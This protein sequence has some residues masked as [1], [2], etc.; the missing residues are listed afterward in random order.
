MMESRDLQ[1]EDEVSSEQATLSA[2]PGLE[3]G[4]VLQSVSGDA[5]RVSDGF[6]R[7]ENALQ[8]SG[9]RLEAG[10]GFPERMAAPEAKEDP[11]ITEG[12]E[13]YERFSEAVKLI[14]QSSDKPI[15]SLQE[16]EQIRA[17]SFSQNPVD[18][19]GVSLL[20]I[21]ANMSERL[22]SGFKV[23]NSEA[24]GMLYAALSQAEVFFRDLRR[25]NGQKFIEIA[26]RMY[27]D[28]F[29]NFGQNLTDADVKLIENT[30]FGAFQKLRT[31]LD[32]L[33]G[34][35]QESVVGQ[36]YTAGQRL[37]DGSGA[38]AGEQAGVDGQAGRLAGAGEAASQTSGGGADGRGRANGPEIEQGPSGNL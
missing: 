3:G 10:S 16:L 27:P 24:G 37:P 4:R 34:E 26:H 17:A 13:S 18:G 14:A 20:G 15:L 1:P 7:A 6:S 31:N 36:A 19:Y 11:V 12:R 22:T 25:Q 2:Q 23:E 29:E 35:G 33:I 9:Q 8:P 21:V 5:G 38:I 30:V 28:I 32:R